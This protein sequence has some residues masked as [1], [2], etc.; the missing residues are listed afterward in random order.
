MTILLV[1]IESVAARACD[2][3]LSVAGLHQSLMLFHW[4]VSHVPFTLDQMTKQMLYTIVKSLSCLPSSLD[5][6]GSSFDLKM[7]FD[8]H[9]CSKHHKAHLHL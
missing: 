4:K 2:K 5:N 6:D 9:H 7:A 1:S 3:P 8:Q